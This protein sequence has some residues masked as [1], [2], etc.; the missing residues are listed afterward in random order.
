M[1]VY[2]D[3]M[4]QRCLEREMIKVKVANDGKTLTTIDYVEKLGISGPGIENI[5]KLFETGRF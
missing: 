5:R 4:H 3:G 2:C 1:L